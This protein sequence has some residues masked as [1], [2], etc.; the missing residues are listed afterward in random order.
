LNLSAI[1]LRKKG[2]EYDESFLYEGSDRLELMKQL[3]M[4]IALAVGFFLSSSMNLYINHFQ[5]F[6]P[7]E[8]REAV[9]SLLLTTNDGD[10]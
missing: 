9:A 8:Q 2:E 10:G 4:D 5:S 6:T 3:P 1:Y 7:Q